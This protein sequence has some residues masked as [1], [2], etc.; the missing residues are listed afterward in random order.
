MM[1][2]LI[3]LALMASVMFLAG[4]KAAAMADRHMET[5]FPEWKSRHPGEKSHSGVTLDKP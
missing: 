4:C 1:M 3:A 5:A 2:V